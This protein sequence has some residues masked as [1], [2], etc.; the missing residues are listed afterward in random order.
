MPSNR[1]RGLWA[2]TETE[3]CPSEDQEICFDCDGDS[4][5]AQVAQGYGGVF[6]LGDIQK[7]S[8]HSHGQL[9]PGDLA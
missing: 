8:G 1:D 5:R 6:I 7:S 4:T 3:E 9:A 2:K